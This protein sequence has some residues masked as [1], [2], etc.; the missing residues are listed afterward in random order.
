MRLLCIATKVCNI[1]HISNKIFHV[2]KTL[3]ATLSISFGNVWQNHG[4]SSENRWATVGE[5]MGNGFRAVAHRFGRGSEGSVIIGADGD[6]LEG[7]RQGEHGRIGLLH[8]LPEPFGGA[9][10]AVNTWRCLRMRLVGGCRYA[11]LREP[12]GGRFLPIDLYGH[13]V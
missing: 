13:F 5:T 8:L 12:C 11:C 4:Q 2:L 6:Q 7:L 1:A 3:R 10:R 9:L